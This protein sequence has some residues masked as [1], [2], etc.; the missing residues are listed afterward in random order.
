MPD[1]SLQVTMANSGDPL[2]R[3]SPV[4]SGVKSWRFLADAVFLDVSE[5]NWMSSLAGNRREGSA[6]T[7]K[8]LSRQELVGHSVSPG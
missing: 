5:E 2:R 1:E 8:L 7:C 4:E 6:K 3:S